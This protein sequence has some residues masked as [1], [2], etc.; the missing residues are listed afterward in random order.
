MYIQTVERD[1]MPT[2]SVVIPCRNDAPMLA[3]CLRGLAEQTRAPDEILVVDNASTDRTAEVCRAFGVRRVRED[4]VGVA[5]ATFRGFDEAA[6]EWLTRIDADSVPPPHWLAQLETALLAAGKD[7][8]VTG[9]GDFYGAAPVILWIAR[10]L[11]I[12]GYRWS[13]NLLMG[14]PPLFGSNF[15]FHRSMWEQVRGRVHRGVPRVHDDLDLSYQLRPWMNVVWD[16]TLRVRVSA[17]PFHTWAGLGRRLAMAYVTFR[18]DF[19]AE[20]PL[21]RR[22]ERR[23]LAGGAV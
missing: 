23:Y 16:E 5:A 19:A 7:T 6:G 15:G 1:A 8:A 18:V 22:R 3:A 12:G 11:Y 21:A 9:P 13:M 4:S 10:N 14:H 17:R 2:I 20:G